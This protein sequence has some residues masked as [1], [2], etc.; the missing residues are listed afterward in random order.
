M[1]SFVIST[2]TTAGQSLD[3]GEFG[4]VAPNG[5]ILAPVGS[6]VT[7]SDTATLI[8]YGAMASAT[9]AGIALDAVTDTSVTIAETGSVVTGGVDLPAI[10]GTFT[11]FFALHNAGALSGGQGVSLTAAAASSQINIA[12][13]GAIQGLGVTVGS[14]LAL[15]LNQTSRAVIANTGTLST[16]GMGATVSAMGNGTVTLTNTGNILNASDLQAAISVEGGLTLRNAGLIEGNVSATQSANIFNSGRIEGNVSLNSFNDVVR[17]SGIVMGDV[18]LGNGVNVFWLTGGRIMGKVMG[19]AGVDT[20]HVDR[21]DVIIDDLTGGVDRVYASVDFRLSDRVEQL[22]LSG[23][24]GLVGIGNAQSNVIVGDA[25]DDTLRGLSGNDAI[26]GGD[27]NNRILGG[28]GQDTLTGG[29]GD[30]VIDGGGG[31]D[32]VRIGFGNDRLTGGAGFDLLSFELITSAG[33]VKYD[34]SGRSASFTDAGT[35]N[36]AGFE[37]VL[38]TLY[39]DDLTGGSGANLLTGGDGDDKL[40]GAGGNDTLNGGAGADTLMGG[41]GLDVFLYSLV[42][43][44]AHA[45]GIDEIDGFVPGTDVISF[46]AIDAVLGGGDNAFTFRG[47]AAFTGDAAEVRYDQDS[48]TNTTLIEVRLAGSVTDDMRIVLD[49]LI[50][51]NSGCFA[52]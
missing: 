27:G 23:S 30:D 34:M 4:F 38:G 15:V 43:D 19:G 10:A 18:L 3:A 2:N 12:N 13:D 32:V 11:G 31:D 14:A 9:A 20:Y 25:G 6:A 50:T 22:Y 45:G 37:A 26:N 7:M 44:S 33:G 1:S 16:A 47:T 29:N 8:S 49:G 42:T 46:V 5:S 52:F 36:I 35:L 39:G 28:F 24:R 17:V 40:N 48:Q 51:L 21:S 41:I